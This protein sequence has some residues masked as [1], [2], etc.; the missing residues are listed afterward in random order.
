M[1]T[2]SGRLDVPAQYSRSSSSP[3]LSSPPRSDSD[4]ARSPPA[5]AYALDSGRD[6]RFRGVERAGTAGGGG[7]SSAAAS[8]AAAAPPTKN[9]S[10]KKL[11]RPRK[12]KST[13]GTTT[14]NA[15][16]KAART[17]KPRSTSGTAGPRK[18]QKI[19][20]PSSDAKQAVLPSRQTKITDVVGAASETR[21]AGTHH[22]HVAGAKA[23]LDVTTASQN[24]NREAIRSLK[25]EPSLPHPTPT[26]PRTSGQNY[27]PIRSA[28]IE[29]S[30]VAPFSPTQKPAAANRASASPSISS[31]IDPPGSSGMPTHKHGHGQATRLHSG[32][33]LPS[34]PGSPSTIE[35]VPAQAPI[36]A[37]HHHRDE[38]DAL[39][40]PTH[41]AAAPTT[42]AAT[43]TKKSAAGASTDAS[44]AAPSPKPA[45]QKAAPPPLPQGNGLLSSALFGGPTSAPKPDAAEKTT[46]TIILDIPM[47]GETNKT[48]NFA[49]MAEERYGFN[50]LYPRIAAQRERL[51]RVAAAGAALGNTDSATGGSGDEMSVDLSEP[52]S[53]APDV[54]GAGAGAPNGEVKK[55]RATKTE[56]YDKDDP[57]VDDSEMLWEEQAAASKDGFFVYSG[58]L[59]PAGEKPTIERA[60]GTAPR[61]GRGRGRGGSTRGDRSS[62]AGRGGAS[63]AEKSSGGGP[64]SRGGSVTRKPRITK[65]DRL[66]REQ[67]K[68]EREKMAT[69]AAKPS[70]YVG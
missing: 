5:V 8:A 30:S 10:A 34:S 55:K 28:N 43:S 52:E 19:S 16:G 15:D 59:V 14:P 53:N 38:D 39:P 26:P 12:E 31:L 50:A 65:A 64:G 21:G 44:S 40:S 67:D 9:T 69:L 68:M 48:V 62:G 4:P 37:G 61:R 70:T 20:E 41:P 57:F 22:D 18:K 60:N 24:G 1:S 36:P 2:P 46:P 11:G 23:S 45:R 54:G 49:R 33:G 3:D 35:V 47:K 7:E 58:P 42:I 6:V 56:E 66:R 63:A 27:D 51:A 32:N 17:K 25:I 29:M 13:N